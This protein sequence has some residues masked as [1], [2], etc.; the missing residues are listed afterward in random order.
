MGSSVV[1]V[2]CTDTWT[3]WVD[4][5]NNVV[6]EGI[7]GN[8]QEYLLC[9]GRCCDNKR[10]SLLAG[11]SDRRC[12]FNILSIVFRYSECCGRQETDLG[13][14]DRMAYWSVSHLPWLIFL[15]GDTNGSAV[16]SIPN[17]QS[18]WSSTGCWL[19]HSGVNF[20][21]YAP[22]DSPGDSRGGVEEHFGRILHYIPT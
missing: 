5:V 3:S 14:R 19:I 21:W 12:K 7:S 8:I 1:P 2:G 13:R 9:S 15:G 10:I 16:P 22:V 20:W 18:Y 6:I 11:F 4:P 17:L